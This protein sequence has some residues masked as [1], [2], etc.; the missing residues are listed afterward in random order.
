MD[1]N[2]AFPVK[3]IVGMGF[4]FL[5]KWV[6]RWQPFEDQAFLCGLLLGVAIVLM[7]QGVYEVGC[8]IARIKK[9]E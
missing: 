8:F 1:K 6:G 2:N 4:M 9:S 3:C 7:I 5:E